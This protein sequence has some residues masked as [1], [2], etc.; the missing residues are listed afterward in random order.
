[1]NDTQ[2]VAPAGRVECP[3]AK[4]PSVRLFIGAAMALVFGVLMVYD[5]Y[6]AKKCPY[7]DSSKSNPYG[8]NAWSNH[9]LNH[10][11][12]FIFLPGGLVLAWW[13][14]VALR[15]VLVADGEGIGYRGKERHA[16]GD[17]TS[18]D[19]S[20]LKT[21]GILVLHFGPSAR[22][23]LDSWKLVGFRDLV[24]FVE[25]HLPPNVTAGV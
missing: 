17:I 9:A 6:I 5:A 4:D 11:G 25:G 3:A 20:R 16:W 14:V 18:V 12:P 15:R 24:A 22:L 7:P 8:I 1:M 2:Q 21:K 13:G 10:Y 19:A 23:V